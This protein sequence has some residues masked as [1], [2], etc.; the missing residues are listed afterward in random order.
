MQSHTGAGDSGSSTLD[1]N[2][3]AA[4]AGGDAVDNGRQIRSIPPWV[5]MAEDDHDPD[6]TQPLLFPNSSVTAKH[7]YLPAPQGHK[8]PGRK[9]DHLRSAEP[10]LL[11]QPLDMS[12]ARWLPYMHAGPQPHDL[13]GARLVS[14][15]WME[16]NVAGMNGPWQAHEDESQG[17]KEKGLWVLDPTR[18]KTVV[19]RAEVSQFLCD[20]RLYHASAD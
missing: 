20:P 14:D 8:A 19:S 12:S 10:A 16:Q 2:A 7:H 4:P 9:W 18:R 1:P 5:L 6:H 3:E 17:D 13:T 15:E 11:D